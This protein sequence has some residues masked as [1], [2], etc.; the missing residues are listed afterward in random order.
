MKGQLEL[1]TEKHPSMLSRDNKKTQRMWFLPLET[2]K[3][4]R[5]A[6]EMAWWARKIA[7]LLGSRRNKDQRETR[8]DEDDWELEQGQ[9]G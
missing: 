7:G 2:Q 5:R 8:S 6:G 3:G 4:E 9:V 1:F